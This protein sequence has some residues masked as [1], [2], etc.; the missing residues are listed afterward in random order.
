MLYAM[1]VPLDQSFE[2][3]NLE[4]PEVVRD[5][6][7]RY[8]EAGARLI[9]TN[10]FG[11]NADRLARHGLEARAGEIN[12][13]AVALAREASK[14]RDVFV[15]GSVG[16]LSRPGTSPDAL[17]KEQRREI[18][19]EQIAALADGGADLLILETFTTLEDLT[20][21]YE[22]ARAACDLPVVA[23]AAFIERQGS[24]PGQEP[25]EVLTE[26]WRLGADVVGTNC[27]RGPRLILEVMQDFAPRAGV[28]LSAF[29][30]SGSPDLI[31]GRYLYLQRPPYLAEVA[32]RLCDLG[33]N[34]IG[35]CC[36]TTPEV[37]AAVA[38]RLRY[39]SVKAR[40]ERPL[41]PRPRVEVGSDPVFPPG[42]LD[43]PDDQ[44]SVVVELDSPRGLDLDAT[45]DGARRMR[46]AGVDL[47]SIAENPL[48]SVRLGNVATAVLMKRY[49]G[50]E[51]LVHFTCRDRNLIGLQSD[52]MGAAAL[53]L[54]YILCITGDPASVVGEVVSKGV[55]ELTSL[56]LV[57]L[58]HGF[59]RG[60][61]AAGASIRKPT[62]FRIGVAFNS[63]V[64]HLHVQL[65]RLR[66][67]S[68]LGAHFALTQPCWDPARIEEILRAA[69]ELPIRLH[70]GVMP[71]ASERNAEFLHNEVPG[72]SVPEEVRRRMRGLSG[73][74]GREMGLRICEELLDVVARHTGRVYLITPFNHY[75][76]TARLAEAF[77]ARL[78]A[79]ARG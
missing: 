22:A 23:Q 24:T 29:F 33:V 69:R 19:R 36:G 52:I 57:K 20:L 68:A 28:P 5:V 53:G 67:K 14:G 13:A 2:G 55:Y 72:M 48:A 27:G 63:N 65:E 62:R 39:R 12:R 56:E 47:V 64:K 3:L 75:D 11:A 16:P 7:R 18:F 61:N 79:R 25:V 8:I 1:G 21:A 37:I 42:F 41:P 15:A 10:T 76:S 73:K 59:N 30:N 77:R 70:V 54:E 6:H 71:L 9:E 43:R 4:R 58:V 78:R 35:G 50:V 66:R 74:A 49:A 45:L 60:F 40:V 34:L 38:E 31:D 26:L 46:D 51:P 17:P 32:E 44:P